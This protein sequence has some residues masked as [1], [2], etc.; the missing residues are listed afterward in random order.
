M[1]LGLTVLLVFAALTEGKACVCKMGSHPQDKFC[2]ADF[3][4]RG[5]VESG[6]VEGY[7][8]YPPQSRGFRHWPKQRDVLVHV[9][10]VTQIFKGAGLV[11]KAGKPVAKQPEEGNPL[12]HN[13]KIYA[14]RSPCPGWL[15]AGTDYL[16]AGLVDDGKLFISSCHW[17]SPWQQVT[18]AQR[19]GVQSVYGES[20]RCRVTSCS[21]LGPGGLI[22]DSH[23]S[24]GY[25]YCG[26]HGLSCAW[27]PVITGSESNEYKKCKASIIPAL[28]QIER[29]HRVVRKH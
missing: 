20:C 8:T 10:M 27:K 11:S 29:R 2:Q 26:E 19:L 25:L 1:A 12:V 5:R 28:H 15:R 3:V 14:D 13:V 4:V 6:P 16:L 7:I 21:F 22:L 24:E 23:C 18:Q 17:T 9:V